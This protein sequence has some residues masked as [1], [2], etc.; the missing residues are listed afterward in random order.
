MITPSAIPK[1]SLLGTSLRLT[2]QF[3][4][5]LGTKSTLRSLEVPKRRTL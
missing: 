2:V 1:V 5:A 3:S 4:Q